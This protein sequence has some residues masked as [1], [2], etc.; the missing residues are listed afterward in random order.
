[1]T[2]T[3]KLVSDIEKGEDIW[4]GLFKKESHKSEGDLP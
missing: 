4:M 1:M 2:K 3:Q